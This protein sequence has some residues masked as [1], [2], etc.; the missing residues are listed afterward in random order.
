MR[1]YIDLITEAARPNPYDDSI[2]YRGTWFPDRL[3]TVGDG[4]NGDM[5]GR[6][7]YLTNDPTY[8]GLF[9]D[10]VEYQLMLGSVFT[11]DSPE[12]SDELFGQRLNDFARQRGYDAIM[13]AVGAGVYQICVFD[14]V[15]INLAEPDY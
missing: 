5:L 8:A 11:P 14:P 4:H 3:P 9:G 15:L 13:V 6:G 7:V 12:W 10:V 1:N 2:W